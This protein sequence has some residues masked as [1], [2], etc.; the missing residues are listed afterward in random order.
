MQKQLLQQQQQQQQQLQYPSVFPSAAQVAGEY[1][2]QESF[3]P[4][5]HNTF[6][7]GQPQQLALPQQQPQSYLS[8]SEFIA[9]NFY[10]TD[11]GSHS[12]PGN[13]LDRKT[14]TTATEGT[15]NQVRSDAVDDAPK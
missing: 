2:L 11:N 6:A 7:K 12:S 9:E 15:S 14:A 4:L 3:A 13:P 10:A 1:G 5:T 8:S